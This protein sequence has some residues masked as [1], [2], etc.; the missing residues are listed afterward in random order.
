[1]INIKGIPLGITNPSIK[2]ISIRFTADTVLNL[3]IGQ[4]LSGEVVNTI[5][6]S[7]AIVK[8]NEFE[9][10]AN[11]TR[12][13][14]NGEHLTVKV[15]S[16]KPQV[17]M[18]LIEKDILPEDKL[19][20][21]LKRLPVQQIDFG[22]SIE[23][24]VKTISG[25]LTDANFKSEPLQK[26]KETLLNFPLKLS[27]DIKPEDI[28]KTIKDSGLFYENKILKLLETGLSKES[29]KG[30]NDDIKNSLMLYLKDSGLTDNNIKTNK[31]LEKGIKGLIN[32]I[33][34]HQSVNI[35]A[36]NDSRISQEQKNFMFQIPYIIQ[37]E[38]KTIKFYLKERGVREG[39]KKSKDEYNLVF[40]LDMVNI[41]MVR[42]NLT[43]KDKN[44]HCHIYTEKGKV[45]SF[46]KQFTPDLTK[47]LSSIG[48]NTTVECSVAKKEYIAKE[49]LPEF[50]NAGDFQLLDIKA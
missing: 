45:A 16:L 38:L 32:N 23:N 28:K 20:S 18:R 48:L 26:F 11:T 22:K 15:E 36:Q 21:I 8:F 33:E 43:V 17:I 34:T 40:I 1:L 49:P 24:L 2:D 46:F 35:L 25:S 7:N 14:T 10:L 42:V 50:L 47:Q 13:L 29:I 41:G 3:N 44:V 6:S 30:L 4:I 37:D 5:D 27:E 9:V 12:E 31:E 19:L 39:E